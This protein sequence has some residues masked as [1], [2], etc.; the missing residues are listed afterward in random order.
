MSTETIRLRVLRGC[1]QAPFVRFPERHAAVAHPSFRGKIFSRRNFTRPD[2][3]EIWIKCCIKKTESGKKKWKKFIKK[4]NEKK[5]DLSFCASFIPG[6][7]DL[8]Q[9][10]KELVVVV[11][12]SSCVLRPAYANR[13]P[14]SAMIPF[15]F[16]QCR[17]SPPCPL[18]TH[19]C[20]CVFSALIVLFGKKND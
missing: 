20:V 5:K 10:D 9:I 19:V 16:E 1:S 2:R 13:S 4:K 12:S 3:L 11:W 18:A 15:Q 17:G 6:P 14:E 7:E 8:R